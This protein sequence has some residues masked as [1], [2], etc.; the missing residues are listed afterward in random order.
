MALVDGAE[1]AGGAPMG[2]SGW[3]RVGLRFGQRRRPREASTVWC[4]RNPRGPLGVA[5]RLW[6]MWEGWI[7]GSVGLRAEDAR[8]TA[9]FGR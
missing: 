2:C 3:R 5:R 4:R 1:G 7:E 9:G 6:V 8:A